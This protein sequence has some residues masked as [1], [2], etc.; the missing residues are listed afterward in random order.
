MN[1]NTTSKT[2]IFKIS[3]IKTYLQ[4][5]RSN[6]KI[7][8]GINLKRKILTIIFLLT[9]TLLFSSCLEKTPLIIINNLPDTYITCLYI[10]QSSDTIW[11]TNRL[12]DS[13]VLLS[14][15][16]SE[17]LL[18]PGKY[19]IQ[20]IDVNG[21][22]YTHNDVNISANGYT[23][24]V[25]EDCADTLTAQIPLN[26]QYTGSCPV[27]FTNTLNENRINGIWIAPSNGDNWGDNHIPGFV[28]N[29]GDTYTA[30]LQPDTYDLYV[31]DETGK[32]CYLWSTQITEDGYTW[33]VIDKEM[34]FE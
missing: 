25:T 19:D 6:N 7:Q 17:T 16:Q 33:N 4:C 18:R 5:I 29:P 3:G 28:L 32:C 15:S 14:G 30:Y 9:I 22:T 2:N 21:L 34:A 1:T 23:W 31:E 11:G 20:V 24:E 8:E 26:L 27:V 13:N 10:S 12:P